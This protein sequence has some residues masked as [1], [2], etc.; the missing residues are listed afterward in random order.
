MEKNL[1]FVAYAGIFIGTGVALGYLLAA[2]PNVELVTATIFLSGYLLGKSGGSLVGVL[3]FGIYSTL[4][5][6]G[7]PPLPLLFTQMFAGGV[8][9]FTGGAIKGRWEG[10]IS[11]T[12][13][14]ILLT[15]FYDIITNASGYFL[16]PQKSTF[17]AY[18][19][20]GIGFS[21]VHI[22]SNGA[23]FPALLFPLTK[24]LKKR[25]LL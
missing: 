14:G 19:I 11:F 21:A 3:T 2:I 15:F 12:I 5:P 24:N 4:N 22:L 16:F 17:I 1:K 25:R 13:S 10:I 23:I 8:I 7:M 18:M 6:Y 9:G 20:A